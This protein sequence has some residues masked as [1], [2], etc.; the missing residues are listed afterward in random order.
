MHLRR[1]LRSVTSVAVL[2][3]IS[4][5]LLPASPAMATCALF[6]DS[7][8]QCFIGGDFYSSTNSPLVGADGFYV[9]MPTQ[10]TLDVRIFDRVNHRLMVGT[11]VPSGSVPAEDV[12]GANTRTIQLASQDNDVEFLGA[13][14]TAGCGSEDTGGANDG[15]TGVNAS[16]GIYKKEFLDWMSCSSTCGYHIRFFDAISNGQVHTYQVQRV[17]SGTTHVFRYWIDGVARWDLTDLPNMTKSESGAY[18]EK[19]GYPDDADALAHNAAQ[20][21]FDDIR[22]HL[23]GAATSRPPGTLNYYAPRVLATQSGWTNIQTCRGLSSPY[24]ITTSGRC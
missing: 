4:S 3:T 18:A 8:S 22:I 14:Y 23:Y 5:I 24:L 19:P 17:S 12:Y 15:C 6:A 16:N 11:V 7:D 21:N 10:G 1:F 2:A 20:A 13:G 9:S